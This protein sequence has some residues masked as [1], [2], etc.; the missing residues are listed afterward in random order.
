[1]SAV[2]S[3]TTD[4]VATYRRNGWVKLPRLI[5]P[6]TAGQMLDEIKSRVGERPAFAARD[7]LREDG[8]SDGTYEYSY[9][10][11]QIVDAVARDLKLAPFRQLAYS[12]EMG[13]TV[14]ALAGRKVAIRLSV[15]GVF[16]K[17]PRG[18][19]GS[20]PTP[21]HQDAQAVHDRTQNVAFFVAL[22]E[23]TPD[24]GTLRY[25]N[26]SHLEGNLGYRSNIPLIEQMRFARS[27]DER[28]L[29]RVY[30]PDIADAYE[31]SE[32]LQ[33]MPGDA[34][35]HHSLV[36][37]GTGENRTKE[38]RWIYSIA[39]IPDDVL[40]TGAPNSKFDGLG[41]RRNAPFDHPNFPII[42]PT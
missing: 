2:R 27:T 17:M 4:E 22:H 38:P 7:H 8:R 5:T 15:E 18:C 33:L 36:C 1:M 20:L 13:R 42:F 26:G 37:H 9:G 3:I 41:L 23:I 28:A 29:A 16:C 31:L 6:H 10:F 21:W 35:V 30:Y 24:M 40:Y 34:T 25:L 32:P 12:A 39:Y 11:L 14:Q 19:A